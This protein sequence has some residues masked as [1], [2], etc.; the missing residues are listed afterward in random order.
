[1]TF[2]STAL[3]MIVGCTWPACSPGPVPISQSPRDPS[4]PSATEG[5]E[6]SAAPKDPTP[7]GAPAQPA[8]TKEHAHHDHNGLGTADPVHRPATT[9]AGSASAVYACPMHPDVTSP[10]PGRCPKCGMNLVP[11]K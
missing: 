5:V 6:P 1:M 10:V 2:R 8:P 11:R 3:C 9:D 4:N 7:S